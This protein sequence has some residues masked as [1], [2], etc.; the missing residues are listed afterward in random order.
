M[1]DKITIELTDINFSYPGTSIGVYGINLTIHEGELLA[2]IGASGCGKSTL[3]KL[4]AGFLTPD[5]G[6]IKIN[7]RDMSGVPPRQRNLGVVFQNYSLFPHMKAW[8]NVAYPLKVR[9]IS[10]QKRYQEAMDVLQR[11]SLPKKF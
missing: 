6:V 4:I 3:L 5:S 10:G 9:N 7:G 8:M 11:V 1:I 2:V